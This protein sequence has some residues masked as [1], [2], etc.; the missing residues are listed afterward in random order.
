MKTSKNTEL[1]NNQTL[2]PMETSE[3]ITPT[4]ESPVFVAECDW[5]GFIEGIYKDFLIETENVSSCGQTFGIHY[6][7][8]ITDLHTWIKEN[9]KV[10]EDYPKCKFNLYLVDGSYDSKTD[11]RKEQK[12]YTISAKNAKRFLF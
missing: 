3:Y 12:I 4:K 5:F 6:D 10:L 8:A 1:L 2:N 11:R 7:K 9:P